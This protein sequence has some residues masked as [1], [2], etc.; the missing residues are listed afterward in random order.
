MC[1]APWEIDV[2]RKWKKP[3][4]DF[5][6]FSDF[7]AL[8]ETQGPLRARCAGGQPAASPAAPPSASHNQAPPHAMS[9]GVWGACAWRLLHAISFG[10]PEDCALP[11]NQKSSICHLLHSLSDLLP[12][13][14]CRNHFRSDLREH[15][16]ENSCATADEVRRFLWSCH[17]RVNSRLGKPQ[18]EWDR[19]C[20]EHVPPT[21][22]LC[23]MPSS[24]FSSKTNHQTCS[25]DPSSELSSSTQATESSDPGYGSLILLHRFAMRIN[26]REKP[27]SVSVEPHSGL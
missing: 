27:V 22:G 24:D 19:L 13:E 11:S 5:S 20:D 3:F 8:F 6:D 17:N 16:P 9:P 4:S 26:A 12:C 2:H 15:P 18:Y 14:R 25:A 1:A 10:L 23:G 7:S 21:Y